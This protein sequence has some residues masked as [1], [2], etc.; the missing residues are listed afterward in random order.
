MTGGDLAKLMPAWQSSRQVHKYAAGELFGRILT[1]PE[2][3]KSHQVGAI[4]QQS[5][6]FEGTVE[7]QTSP[8]KMQP[9]VGVSITTILAK[10]GNAGFSRCQIH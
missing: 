9:E 2:S 7:V 1:A 5:G 6:A 8:R 3:S 4:R 10:P